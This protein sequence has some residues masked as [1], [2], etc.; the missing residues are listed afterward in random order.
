MEK[1]EIC[2]TEICFTEFVLDFCKIK[3]YSFLHDLLVNNEYSEIG[4]L[5]TAQYTAQVT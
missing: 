2:F 4:A 5:I 1:I 3:R